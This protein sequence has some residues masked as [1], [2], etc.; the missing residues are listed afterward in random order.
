VAKSKPVITRVVPAKNSP[1]SRNPVRSDGSPRNHTAIK[2]VPTIR[3]MAALFMAGQYS[4]RYRP[5][6]A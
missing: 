2:T 5:R 6:I 3:E 1:M 4:R